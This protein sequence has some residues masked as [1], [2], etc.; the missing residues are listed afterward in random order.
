MYTNQRL[1][2]AWLCSNL[3]IGASTDFT[4]SYRRP[5]PPARRAPCADGVKGLQHRT[6]T[7]GYPYA[8]ACSRLRST[9]WILLV[10]AR[11]KWETMRRRRMAAGKHT[12]QTVPWTDTFSALIPP[13]TYSLLP[14]TDDARQPFSL[15]LAQL[16]LRRCAL[17]RVVRNGAF[18]WHVCVLAQRVARLSGWNSLHRRRWSESGAASSSLW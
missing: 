11:E 13:L 16:Q 17:C 5:G 1:V 18:R 10:A 6:A 12:T 15:G 2:Y 4:S 9:T 7:M 3:A 8:I 14:F